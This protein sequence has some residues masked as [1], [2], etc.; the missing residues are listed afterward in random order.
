MSG[1]PVQTPEILQ[2]INTI[3]VQLVS[4]VETYGPVIMALS[5]LFFAVWFV[6]QIGRLC[7]GIIHRTS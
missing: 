7:Y 2:L 3:I 1:V 5:L 4:L 6:F